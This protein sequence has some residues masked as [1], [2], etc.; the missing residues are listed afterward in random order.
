[1]RAVGQPSDPVG[2]LP[3]SANADHLEPLAEERMGA[4]GDTDLY[5]PITKLLCIL[6]CIAVREADKDGQSQPSLASIER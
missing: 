5:R 6:V 4:V 2:L 1:M 3:L